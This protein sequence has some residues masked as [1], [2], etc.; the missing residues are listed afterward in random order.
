M[1]PDPR[2]PIRQIVSI[3]RTTSPHEALL[4]LSCGHVSHCAG[5]FTYKCG[6]DSHC[7]ECGQQA[8]HSADIV[9]GYNRD[10]LGESS[11]Y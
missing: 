5:H 11:D 7:F 3:E 1:T 9:D 10:D 4:T 8:K 2:G 6:R